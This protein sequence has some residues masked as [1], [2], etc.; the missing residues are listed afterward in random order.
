MEQKNDFVKQN[1]FKSKD[2]TFSK[3]K[4]KAPEF[5]NILLPP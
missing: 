1:F 5:V 2:V 3:I 4:I